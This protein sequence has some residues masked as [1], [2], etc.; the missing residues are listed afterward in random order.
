M[1]CVFYK[2]QVSRRHKYLTSV[3]SM[4]KKAPRVGKAEMEG[5][6]LEHIAPVSFRH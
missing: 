6:D 4:R 3:K 2:M 1:I 5:S